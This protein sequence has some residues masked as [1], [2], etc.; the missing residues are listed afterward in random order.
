MTIPYPNVPKY[1]LLLPVSNKKIQYRPFLVKEEKILLMA[2]EGIEAM[3]TAVKQVLEQCTMGMVDI[4]NMPM[5]D[6]ELLFIKIRSRSISE[7]IDSVVTCPSCKAKIN[8]NIDLDKAKVI[9][10]TMSCDI[11]IDDTTIVSMKYPTFST[12]ANSDDD[13]LN[14][15]AD[16]IT[17]ITM[18]ENM[19]ETQDFTREQLLD[20]IDHLSKAQLDKISEFLGNIP[21]LVYDETITCTCGS[22]IH[23]YMEGLE[24]F[25][26]Y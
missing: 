5:A 8:Y 24:S 23:V 18:G 2:N 26:E 3:T 25:F 19:Y 4:D 17:A 21:K 10:N 9:Q 13:P 6:I 11:A 14:E 16:M 20:W 22:P 1:N 15:T 12:V 7:T